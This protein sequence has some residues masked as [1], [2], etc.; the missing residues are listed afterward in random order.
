MYI[1]KS[2]KN[3]MRLTDL[4]QSFE[5][6]TVRSNCSPF[7]V[8]SSDAAEMWNHLTVASAPFYRIFLSQLTKTQLRLAYRRVFRHLNETAWPRTAP[9]FFLP[10]AARQ[11]TVLEHMWWRAQ[12]RFWVREVRT[13][14]D[15]IR[16]YHNGTSAHY[17]LFSAMKRWIVNEWVAG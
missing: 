16:E 11:T 7:R 8:T 9:I 12:P 4:P 17:R 2:T 3:K 1:L 14:D 6:K 15:A 5:D 13:A 10:S